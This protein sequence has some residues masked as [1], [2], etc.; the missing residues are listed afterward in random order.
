[1]FEITAVK[2]GIDLKGKVTLGSKFKMEITFIKFQECDLP[3][4]RKWLDEPHVKIFWQET[5]DDAALTEKIFKRFP[6]AGIEAFL[7][8]LDDL[9]VGYIQSYEACR[10]GDGWWPEAKPGQYGIDLLIGNPLFTG[11][12]WGAKIISAYIEKLKTE[13]TVTEIIIDPE[14]NN[15]R[16]IS[17]YEKA[18]FSKVGI[19]DTPNGKACLMSFKIKKAG[20]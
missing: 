10:V 5:E 15:M 2:S 14:P 17:A 3:T 6:K 19:I 20:N 11:K 7:I 13:K 9:T 16:A 12:G 8:M 18:G 1:M 4:F